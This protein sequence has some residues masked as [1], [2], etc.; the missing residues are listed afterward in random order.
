MEKKH[1]LIF[2][3]FLT[4]LFLIN[5]IIGSQL[6]L[7]FDEAYYWIY[8]EH[9][10]WGYYD[11]PPMVAW[12]IRLGTS[13][14]GNTEFAVRLIFNLS[15]C[16]SSTLLFFMTEK[17]NCLSLIFLF[18]SFPLLS[19]SGIFALPDG[20]LLLFATGYFFILKKYI[21]ENTLLNTVLLSLAI[22]GMFYSKY[23]GLLIVILTVLANPKFLK[24]KTFWLCSVLVT[25]MYLPHMYW[26][27]V[28]D[29]ISFKFHLTGRSEK[30]FELSNIFNFLTGQ[31]FL[32]GLTLVPLFIVERKRKLE[33]DIFTK[34]LY[35][36]SFGF[37]LF[38]FFLSFRNQIEANWSSTCALALILIY[39]SNERL[40]KRLY[41]LTGLP[42]L[43]GIFFR[44]VLLDPGWWAQKVNIKENRLHEVS[45]WKSER[46]PAIKKI[47]AD[48]RIVADSYQVAA[49]TSFY[50]NQLVPALHIDSRKSQYSL[51]NL[52]RE[53]KKNASIC[54]LSN[55]PIE[56]SVRI[57]TGYR[58][59]LYVIPKT[60]IDK[61]LK[62][63][64]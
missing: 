37:L 56:K 22:V 29:F 18:L 20:A 19:F 2:I 43:M 4:I 63:V 27:Y 62:K 7:S 12:F 14:F 53:I 33:K 45:F 40:K 5:L 6:E 8:S 50:L 24:Q 21:Q 54:Y 9:L 39:T 35:Y 3:G 57:D 41:L 36:N 61:I 42:V 10:A 59:P 1:N 64:D 47:C 55:D 31:L 23:H 26:Q 44:I 49:K 17:K 60:S 46:I 34:I 51:L 13:L 25:L 16:L 28:N 11:H 52:E 15:L 58:T 30:H 48:T 38:L 32:M